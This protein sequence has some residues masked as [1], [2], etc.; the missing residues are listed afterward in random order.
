MLTE[1][2]IFIG[3]PGA[4]KSSLYREKFASTHL[5]VNKDLWPNA[6]KREDR[7]REMI[8]EAQRIRD[9]DRRLTRGATESPAE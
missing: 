8:E 6:T 3:L 4:G 7:Q 1:C 5:H 2:V 9:E